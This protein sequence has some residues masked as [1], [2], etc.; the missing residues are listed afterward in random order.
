MSLKVA[1]F[2]RL[3]MVSYYSFLVTLPLKRTV[4]EINNFKNV[5]TVKIG[6]G[7]RQ[8]HLKYHP[9]IERLRLPIEVL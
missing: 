8:G 4:F 7:V 1:T 3:C 2:G 5:V 6:V 9:S